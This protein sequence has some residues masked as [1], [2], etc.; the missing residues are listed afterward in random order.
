M[1]LH[2]VGATNM[3]P[4]S[5]SAIKLDF[6]KLRNKVDLA[7]KAIAFILAISLSKLKTHVVRK[8][9]YTVII[10]SDGKKNPLNCLQN[11]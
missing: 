7:I 5:T 6:P 11:V 3:A 10:D 4:A 9:R 2:S 8:K 1:K